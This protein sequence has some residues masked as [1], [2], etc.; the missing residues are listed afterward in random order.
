M[1]MELLSMKYWD[2]FYPNKNDLKEAKKEQLEK[3]LEGLPWIAA[4]F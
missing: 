3:A 4:I 1:S 2:V